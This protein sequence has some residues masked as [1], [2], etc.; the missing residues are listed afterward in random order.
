M[1][2]DQYCVSRFKLGMDDENTEHVKFLDT[3]VLG[4]FYALLGKP[5]N[6]GVTA[7]N[8]CSKFLQIPSRPNTSTS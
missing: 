4:T 6:W 3:V 8:H 5:R 2:M 7:I 1:E